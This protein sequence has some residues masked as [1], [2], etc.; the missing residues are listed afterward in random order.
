[1]TVFRGAWGVTFALA[2]S[3]CQ[4]E[5]HDKATRQITA[6]PRPPTSSIGR[7]VFLLGRPHCGQARADEETPLPQSGHLRKLTT[8]S[9]RIG[10][11]RQEIGPWDIRFQQARHG[12]GAVSCATAVF[13]TNALLA[14]NDRFTIAAGYPKV[15]P[16]AE[17]HIYILRL[18]LS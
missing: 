8:N 15:H 7:R 14:R 2:V 5:G 13:P 1:M 12:E 6:K 10:A 3:S 11:T 9:P 4:V 18:W 16:R 17:S